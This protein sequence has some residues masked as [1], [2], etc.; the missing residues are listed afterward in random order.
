MNQ[1]TDKYDRLT[2]ARLLELFIYDPDSGRLLW[3]FRPE[4]PKHWN[5][6]YAGR[7][8]TAPGKGGY[9]VVSVRVDGLRAN[10][11]VHRIVWAMMTGQWPDVFLEVDHRDGNRTNN[12][13]LNLRLVTAHQNRM[14]TTVAR[15]NTGLK[16]VYI[17]SQ[18]QKYQSRIRVCGKDVHL[19]YF[20][21]REDAARAYDA[22]A[23][24][25]FGE[26]AK[27]NAALGL[28]G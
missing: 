14:N 27:T 11:L 23:T 12:R 7:E 25:H 19:G 28:I 21:R 6:R 9:Y 13:W 16:G 22:A 18:T 24:R 26:F 4:G 15:G 3:R 1:P 20:Y 8:A 10:Y 17:V 2:V 5:T